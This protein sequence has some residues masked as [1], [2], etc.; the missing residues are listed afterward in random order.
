[1]VF[2]FVFLWGGRGGGGLCEGVG[3]GGDFH[4]FVGWG[5]VGG[6]LVRGSRPMDGFRFVFFVGW[7]GGG[8]ALFQAP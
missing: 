6:G 5:G 8:E 7:A 1:M 4:F 2:R 3:L